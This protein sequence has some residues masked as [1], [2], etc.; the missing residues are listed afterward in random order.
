MTE[1]KKH[2]GRNV[3][4]IREIVGMK[5]EALAAGLGV[6]QQRMS[7]IEQKE[8]IDDELML[9]I[10]EILKVPAEAIRNFDEQATVSILSNTFHEHAIIANSGT[11]TINPVEK[12]IEAIKKNEELYEALL[13]A[14][15]E[16]IALLEKMLNR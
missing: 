6:N 14:E 3:K 1:T 2:E 16:K 8:E 9:R 10:A 13:K 7:A 15:R 5:Q 12:W 4:R 11:V